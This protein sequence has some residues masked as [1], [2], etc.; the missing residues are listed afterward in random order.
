M[1]DATHVLAAVH[2]LDLGPALCRLP[3]S[4]TDA[5]PATQGVVGHAAMVYAICLGAKCRPSASFTGIMCQ[6]RVPIEGAITQADPD[7]Y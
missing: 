5:Q 3:L 6:D 2:D 4:T 1:I 7:L